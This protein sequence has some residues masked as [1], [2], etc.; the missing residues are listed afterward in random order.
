M[1][2]DS[3]LKPKTQ[4]K[5]IVTI[6]WGFGLIVSDSGKKVRVLVLV[7]ERNQAQGLL[8]LFNPTVHIMNID[9]EGV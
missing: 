4:V 6:F 5:K 7:S 8:T 3:F 2:K 9:K 1:I